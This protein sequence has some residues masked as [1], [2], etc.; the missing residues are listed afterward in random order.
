MKTAMSWLTTLGG[1]EMW[2]L[3]IWFLTWLSADPND[4]DIAHA[5]SSAAISAARASMN[6]TR[7]C[8]GLCEGGVITYPDGTTSIC[9]CPD[10]CPCKECKECRI[11]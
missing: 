3:F 4:L 2:R 1:G 5:R 9:P 8:C 7:M 6:P 10:T 11:D